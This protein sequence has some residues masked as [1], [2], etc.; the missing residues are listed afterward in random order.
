MYNREN[1]ETFV[2]G[3]SS[4]SVSCLCMGEDGAG[5]PS[6]TCC[7]YTSVCFNVFYVSHFTKCFVTYDRQTLLGIKGIT[8]ELLRDA[9]CGAQFASPL[10]T[11]P[12]YLRRL[13]G[14]LPGR[15]RRKRRGRR[16]GFAV[17]LKLLSKSDFLPHSGLCT[18]MAG[19]GRFIAGCALEPLYAWNIPIAGDPLDQPPRSRPPRLRRGGVCISHLRSLSRASDQTIDSREIRMSLINARSVSNKTVIINDF[20]NSCTLD[21]L[22]ITET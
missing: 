22:F 6:A 21:F 2:F 13:S 9:K 8:E 7:A 12:D 20:F 10:A 14:P 19:R 4:E 15:K 17:K 18:Y 1:T 3:G 5:V 11:I 16:G